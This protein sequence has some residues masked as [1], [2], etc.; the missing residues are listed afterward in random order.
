MMSEHPG[1]I[2]ALEPVAAA[3]QALGVRF[4]VGGSVASSFHGVARSTMVQAQIK[5][6]MP[7]TQIADS[8]YFNH[9]NNRFIFLAFESRQRHCL[10]PGNTRISI[11]STFS[12]LAIVM[13]AGSAS[14]FAPADS[15]IAVAATGDLSRFVEAGTRCMTA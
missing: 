10:Q 9:A 3:L 7:R 5:I 14:Q 15:E 13:P 1:L 4:Y 8:K 2:E 12:P 11:P 6:L